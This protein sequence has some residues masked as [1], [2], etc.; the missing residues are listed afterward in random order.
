MKLV[1]ILFG[2]LL[3]CVILV[4]FSFCGLLLTQNNAYIIALLVCTSAM[5]YVSYSLYQLEPGRKAKVQKEYSFY[6]I[7][8]HAPT[9]DMFSRQM[10]NRM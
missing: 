3:L 9:D 5:I 7:L 4:E 1:E 10:R 8:D 6:Y 2:K